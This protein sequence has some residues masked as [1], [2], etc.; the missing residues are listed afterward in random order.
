M[1]SWGG[2]CLSHIPRNTNCLKT[3]IPKFLPFHPS[4]QRFS[5]LEKLQTSWGVFGAADS[6]GGGVLSIGYDLLPIFP[7]NQE[8]LSHFQ[9][10]HSW[11]AQL[12]NVSS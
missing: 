3:T 6:T 4:P 1:I 10:S 2:G 12:A 8:V 11:G 5:L 9:Q 7:Q